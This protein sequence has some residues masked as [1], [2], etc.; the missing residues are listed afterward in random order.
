MIRFNSS[1][2][3][4][5]LF[6]SATFPACAQTEGAAPENAAPSYV[7]L[8][9]A[10]TAL[11]V[12]P[13]SAEV[14]REFD[15]PDFYTKGIMVRGMPIT[16]SAKASDY[17]LLECAY[18]LDHMFAD[19]PQWVLS[20]LTAS[21]IRMSVMSSSEYTMD[22]PDNQSWQTDRSLEKMAF[23]DKRARGMGGLPAAS[24]AEENLLNLSSDPYKD[25]NITIHEFSHTVA[26]ALQV[27]DPQWYE[28]LTATYNAA[29]KAGRFANSYAANSVQEYWAEGT[30]SWFS[31]NSPA[32]NTIHNGIWNRELLK[33]YD[34]DLSKILA[35]VY[36]DGTWRYIRTDGKPLV[37]GDKTYTRST[38]D[39]AHLQGLDRSQL[40]AF[41]FAKSKN[42]QAFEASKKTENKAKE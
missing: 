13:I 21:K 15:I 28:N 29:M 41:D 2:L 25:E 40:P 19:S 12:A 16:S 39:L 35:G 22:L 3:L 37:I 23:W 4:C 10:P 7:P 8:P 42:I 34:P 20:A 14:R 6:I 17:A 24:C 9:V 32:K 30:Q 31:C 26:S 36:G 11:V 1:L 5:G 38:A 18:D 27:A 33:D